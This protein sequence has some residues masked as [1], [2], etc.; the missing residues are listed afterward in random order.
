MPHFLEILFS[1]MMVPQ[2]LKVRIFVLVELL[3]DFLKAGVFF[4][5]ILDGKALFLLVHE[6]V[7]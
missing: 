6:V 4:G 7:D 3:F 2:A 5:Q 1:F